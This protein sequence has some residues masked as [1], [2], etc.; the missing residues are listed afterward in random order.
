MGTSRLAPGKGLKFAEL[1]GAG[2]S[3]NNVVGGSAGALFADSTPR[4]RSSSSVTARRYGVYGMGLRSTG[5]P[6]LHLPPR[7]LAAPRSMGPA[8]WGRGQSYRRIRVGN[9]ARSV[10]LARSR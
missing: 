5:T 2:P 7:A 9:A 6:P 8:A 10:R 3:L 1:A 4:A